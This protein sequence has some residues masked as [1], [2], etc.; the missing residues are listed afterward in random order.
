MSIVKINYQLEST[1]EAPSAKAL[2]KLTAAKAASLYAAGP[3]YLAHARRVLKNST[4]AEDDEHVEAERKRLQELAAANGEGADEYADIGDEPESKELLESDPK[5]WK[6]QDHYEVLG[7]SA[8]RYKATPD[9]IKRAH[10][11][12]VLRHHP[13]KK[14]GSGETNDDSFFKCIAKA[15][16]ILYNPAKR[17]QFDSVDPGVNDDDVPS[18]SKKPASAEE[19]VE[20]YAPVFERE[21]RFSKVTPVAP[22]GGADASK[23]EVEAFY[24]FWYNFDSWRSFEYLD[25]EA[26]EGADSRDEKRYAEKKNKNERARR[27]KEDIARVRALVDQAM[28][29]DPRIKRIKAEEKLAREMKKKGGSRT[30]TPGNV[31]P[32]D[33]EQAAAEAKAK[34]EAEAKKAEDDKKKAESD[35]ADREAAKK[36]REAA[37]KNLKR[38]KKAARAVITSLNYLLPEGQAPSASLIDNQLTELDAILEALEPTAAPDMRKAMEAKKDDR[39]AV[40]A[41]VIEW[42]GKAGK[43]DLKGFA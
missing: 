22:L 14:A 20:L 35:K 23:A 36:A 3:G 37:K 39:E 13:D 27:K 43:S 38:E 24:S 15:F 8:L 40:K 25:K 34:A 32:Q 4:F 1:S 33:K 30:G 2:G 12:K 42:A 6:D 17:M 28:A 18:A 41:V 16:D 21:G 10:R 19:F 31:T 29:A 11:R 9:Q 7:L 5:Q 26:N